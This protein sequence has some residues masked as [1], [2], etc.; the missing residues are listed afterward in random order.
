MRIKAKIKG[1]SLIV[2]ARASF[3]ENLDEES[4]GM[5]ARTNT[6]LFLKPRVLRRNVVEYSGPVGICL[7]DRL[8]NPITQL[9][10]L[11]I[12]AFM[13]GK[14]DGNWIYFIFGGG[15]VLLMAIIGSAMN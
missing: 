14:E 7:R 10:F 4:L 9:D 15:A 5:L 12:I 6:R 13:I 1:L 11:Y 8:R 2:K 3:G